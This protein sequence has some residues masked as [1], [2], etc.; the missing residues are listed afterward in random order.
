[1]MDEVVQT[2]SEIRIGRMMSAKA[3]MLWLRN[4]LATLGM[5]AAALFL[6]E[7]VLKTM[8]WPEA[9]LAHDPRVTV[10]HLRNAALIATA[11]ASVGVLVS[12]FATAY[13]FHGFVYAV[14][15]TIVALV[16]T[17]LLLIGPL[18]LTQLVASDIRRHFQ[19]R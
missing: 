17:P 19:A 10:V 4:F 8:D 18:A 9:G 2:D 7:L 3:R 13:Y 5:I 16:F 14:L 15:H 12:L 11:L 6:V 1:M